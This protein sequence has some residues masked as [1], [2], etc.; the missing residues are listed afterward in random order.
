MKIKFLDAKEFE[1]NLKCTVQSN[2]KL[3]FSAAAIKILQL[4]NQKSVKFA[5][6]EDAKGLEELYIILQDHITDDAFKVNKA[7]NYYYLNAK[8]LFDSLGIDYRVNSVIF[9]IT[10]TNEMFDGLPLYKLNKRKGKSRR[11]K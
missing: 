6:N 2:G 9:D 1:A 5:V 10:K 4:N 3:N 8:A 7:G 11:V